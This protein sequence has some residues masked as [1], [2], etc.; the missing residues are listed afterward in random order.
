MFIVIESKEK[1]I[2]NKDNLL[3]LQEKYLSV[4]YKYRI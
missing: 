3:Y 4:L 2:G 1:V